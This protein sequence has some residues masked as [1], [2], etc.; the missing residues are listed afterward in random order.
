MIPIRL[1]VKNFL[2]YRA[3][4]PVRFDGIHL[5]CLTGPNGAGKSSLLDAITWAL[6]GR[7]R[8]KRDDDMIYMS[9]SDM[10]VQLDFEQEGIVYRVIRKRSRRQRGVGSLDL[11]AQVD[12]EWVTQS[13]PSIRDT[14]NK[15]NRLL[16]LDYETFVH[17]AFLQQGKADAFTTKPPAQRKQ[18]LSDIL[19]LAAWEQY[20]EATK[21]M[22]KNISSELSVIDLRVAEI[23]GELRKEPQLRKVLEEAEQAQR[24]AQAL[25]GAAEQKLE[26][27]AHAPAQMRAAQERLAECERH[28]REHQRDLQTIAEDI[29]RQQARIADYQAIIEARADIEAGYAALQSA[30]QADSALGEKLMQL[31]DFDTQRHELEK[32]L[33]DAR[34]ELENELSAYEARIA[35]LRLALELADPDELNVV[36]S[37]V[38][39]LQELQNT[40]DQ[41]DERARLLAEERAELAGEQK[42]LEAEGQTINK[43]L[44]ELQATQEPICPL[45]GQPLDEEHRTQIISQLEADIEGRRA[46]YRANQERAKQINSDHKE[47]KAQVA[48]LDLELK[49]LT[50]LIER[51]SVLQ[52]Q[53][54]S[55]TTAEARILEEQA[56]LDAVRA[57]LEQETYAQDI[58]QQLAAL[59]GQRAQIGYDRSSHDSARQQVETYHEYETRQKQLEIALSALPDVQAALDGA[60][61][62]QERTQ[63]A[64]SEDAEKIDALKGEIAQLEAL[65]KE[66]QVRQAEVNRLRMFERTQYQRL[67]NAQ[68]ELDVL[69]KQRQRKEELEARREQRRHDEALYKELRAAFGKNGVPAMIIEAVIPELETSANRLLARMT[70]GRMQLNFTTQKE[71]AAGEGV[72]ETLEIQIADELGTRSYELYSGGEAFR[73]NFAVRVALSQLLA[74]RAGAHLRT[75][76]IDEGFG[77]QDEDG[78]NKLIEAINAVQDDFD[79]ILVI[80]HLDD[81]RDSFPVHVVV[82]KTPNG[83]RVSVR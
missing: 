40:R 63:K 10:H 69:D 47:A 29:T 6:W 52:A 16:R 41:F 75:L 68:Q 50:P 82:E 9:Q 19:G 18:I 33:M 58:R 43:R 3:P 46:I 51:A 74:R 76:F 64:L 11:F 81:L 2:A 71:K 61:L 25:L 21:E 59:D 13:E 35:E 80:T 23:E 39:T 30:R 26:E 78:R 28:Q 79:L 65:V 62:R 34:A 12:D 60:M 73:I 8:A 54:D 32:R 5:A 37:E 27:V 4:D 49:R 15:I 70:D 55:A 17:S 83:S 7:A 44:A 20:E 36:Q 77:T 31:S 66:Q 24:E 38:F 57:M 72:I 14:Q 1:E 53:I 45:C 22:L 67:L 48:E 56:R 42:T